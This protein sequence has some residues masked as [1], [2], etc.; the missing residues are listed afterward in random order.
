MRHR[1]GDA[2]LRDLGSQLL[3]T[4]AAADQAVDAVSVLPRGQGFEQLQRLLAGGS[5]PAA[6]EA[7]ARLVTAAS[8]VP[9]WVDWNAVARGG[10]VFLRAG[11]AGGI[12]LGMNSLVLGYASPGG[13]KPLVLSGRLQ[14][15]AARRLAET[16]RFV[17]AVTRP[18]GLRRFGEGF[19]ITVKVRFMHAHVRRLIAAGGRWNCS[20]WGEPINQHDMVGTIL[21]FSVAAVE[22]LR[23][24]GYEVSPAEAEDVVHL[25]RYVG[26]VIGVDPALLPASQRQ[27]MILAETI[28]DTQG[29][30]DDDARAL[31]RALFEA[32]LSLATSPRQK[33]MAQLRLGVMQGIARRLIGDP[34]ADQLAIPPN[35][36][37]HV[38]AAV[39]PAL[40]LAARVNRLPLW[41]DL[42]TRVGDRYWE[43]A[44]AFGM[45]DHRAQ[46][47][48]PAVRE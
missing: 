7:L 40:G 22:G 42:A 2:L 43:S 29:P 33:R 21:L 17:Q 30:P 12:V 13:N 27:A 41:R 4:D 35:L 45:G 36:W 23:R 26:H 15:Q 32:R 39:R 19:A 1:Y 48:P 24:L 28:R 38:G 5:V 11:L 10:A 20:L 37:Q 6:P 14:E 44:I 47:A 8:E 25:W 9:P 16:S 34:L 18:D 31:V 3:V 46:F